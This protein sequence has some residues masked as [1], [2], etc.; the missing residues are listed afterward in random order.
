MDNPTVRRAKAGLQG[1]GQ[2]RV[3]TPR[4]ALSAIRAGTTPG[5]RP[6]NTLVVARDIEINGEINAC[7]D[8]VVEGR[9]AATVEAEQLDVAE[10]GTFSGEAVVENA[11]ILGVFEGGLTVRD[12]LRLGPKA[13]V[14]G[15]V[16]YGRLAVRCGGQLSGDIAAVDEI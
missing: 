3:F 9:L 8:L 2:A 16:R 5:Y 13:K 14:T 4:G 10:S 11:E 12:E 1:P 15:R 7:R 6:N